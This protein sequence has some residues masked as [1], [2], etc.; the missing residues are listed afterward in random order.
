METSQRE[1]DDDADDVMKL[2]PDWQYDDSKSIIC[3]TTVGIIPKAYSAYVHSSSINIFWG[4]RL[5]QP[6]RNFK[7]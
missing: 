2:P 6:G 7:K 3:Q 1:N 4:R 5:R